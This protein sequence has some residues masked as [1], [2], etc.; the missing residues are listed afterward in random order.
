[1][2]HRRSVILAV[3]I[4]AFLMVSLPAQAAAPGVGVVVDGRLLA[5]TGMV[6]NGTTYVPLR[7]V[8]ESLGATATWDGTT[9][10][11]Y[12]TS[13]PAP[14]PTVVDRVVPQ[15]IPA[16][17]SEVPFDAA[18]VYKA[19][20]NAA[21]SVDI[22][23]S[24]RGYRGSGFTVAPGRVVTAWHVLA[25]MVNSGGPFAISVATKGQGSRPATILAHDERLDIA[26]LSVPSMPGAYPVL[27]V[28]SQPPEV[29]E[30]VAVVSSPLVAKW[31]LTVGYVSG[32]GSEQPGTMLL[33]VALA[34]GSSGAPVLD[35]Q[36]EVVGMAVGLYDDAPRL[37]TAVPASVLASFLAGK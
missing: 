32:E 6:V 23:D 18:A 14:P 27:K 1:M 28:A 13:P 9:S 24:A 36:G 25:E 12:I 29:G 11:V 19:A 31:V 7:A 5:S 15:V 35:E 21:W 4:V 33:D 2:T 17:G 26:L 20:I 10:T 30:R 34:H 16:S 37:G 3:F 8:S 22:F